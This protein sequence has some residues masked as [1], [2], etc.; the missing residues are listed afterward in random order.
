MRGPA[1][2][3]VSV[4]VLLGP[5]TLPSAAIAASE[6]ARLLGMDP[7]LIPEVLSAVTYDGR[8]VPRRESLAAAQVLDRLGSTRIPQVDH[9]APPDWVAIGLHDSSGPG[10]RWIGY[11]DPFNPQCPS[12][13]VSPT[14]FSAPET[15]FAPS[16]ELVSIAGDAG[17]G[18][19]YATLVFGVSDHIGFSVLHEAVASR[20]DSP[21]FRL[22]DAG[23]ICITWSYATKGLVWVAGDGLV[24]GCYPFFFS[25]C[26]SSPLPP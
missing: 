11:P 3:M 10:F 20:I 14:G 1:V 5:A 18:Y 13:T 22:Q 21:A 2:I 6:L 4:V 25:A 15:P 9:T 16:G 19:A 26:N 23:V 17:R 24:T 8:G 12:L 7:S